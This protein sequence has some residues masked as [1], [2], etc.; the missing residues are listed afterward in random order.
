MSDNQNKVTV[1][2]PVNKQPL[3]KKGLNNFMAMPLSDKILFFV[4]IYC[5]ITLSLYLFWGFNLCINSDGASASTLALEIIRSGT[6]IP[7]E[8]TYNGDLWM[9]FLH[10]PIAL[11]YFFTHDLI[12]SRGIATIICMLIAS[13]GIIW[14]SKSVFKNNSW[15]LIL[16][17]LYSGIP[18]NTSPLCYSAEPWFNYSNMI[19]NLIYIFYIVALF[20]SSVDENFNIRSKLKFVLLCILMAVACA[21]GPRILQSTALPLLGSIVLYFIITNFNCSLKE[22]I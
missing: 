15:I 22:S 9:F 5:L 11:I 2:E 13:L 21:S 8:W 20:V 17:L 18:F 12:I 14:T 1:I 19:Q 3:W 10:V 16:I 6:L 4:L 7:S